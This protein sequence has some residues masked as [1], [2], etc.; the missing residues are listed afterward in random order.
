MVQN[1]KAF[2]EL[3]YTY[4]NRVPTLPKA[5]ILQAAKAVKYVLDDNL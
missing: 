1:G 2:V 3:T 5:Y 4:N